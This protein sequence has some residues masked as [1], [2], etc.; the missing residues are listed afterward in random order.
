MNMGFADA[1]DGDRL[2][3]LVTKAGSAVKVMVAVGG[4]TFS[5][6]AT[7]DIFSTMIASPDNRTKF[8]A[9]AKS[10]ISAYGIAG[11]DI[12][13]EYPASVERGGPP[14]DTPNLTLFFQEF[15]AGLGSSALISLATPAGYWFL[16]GFE[17]DKISPELSFFNMMSY[18]YHGP[19]DTTVPGANSTAQPQSS[20][21]DM[22]D[23][24]KLYVKAGV[25][26]NKV[27]L[28]LAWYGRTFELEQSSCEGYNCDMKGGGTKGVCTGESGVLANFEINQVLI[29]ADVRPRLDTASQTNWFTHGSDL[30]TYDDD[31][32]LTAKTNFAKSACFGGTMIWS[33]DQNI[34]ADNADP[35]DGVAYPVVK[36][37]ETNPFGAL[38]EVEKA[39]TCK[40]YGTRIYTSRLWHIPSGQDWTEA[41]KGSPM[42]I[43]QV[44]YESPDVCD[45]LGVFGM[46]GTWYVSS[47]DS[48][49]LP[50]W[51]DKTEDECVDNSVRKWYARLW[52][53]SGD[54]D[55]M[56]MCTTT[57]ATVDGNHYD[58]PSQCDDKGILG[59]WGVWNVP[60][61]S[62]SGNWGS[63]KDNG[64]ADT[65]GKREWSSKLFDIV[66]GWEEACAARD[67]TVEDEYFSTPTKCEKHITGIWGVFETMDPTCGTPPC[68]SNKVW[69]FDANG[70][71]DCNGA[72]RLLPPRELSNFERAVEYNRST[73]AFS[74]NERQRR[75]YG[76]MT[77]APRHTLQKRAGD[78]LPFHLPRPA[79]DLMPNNLLAW[80]DD[81]GNGG[82]AAEGP[83]AAQIATR[84]EVLSAF[85]EAWTDSFP[86]RNTAQEI[87]HPTGRVHV[88][89]AQRSRSNTMN[90]T[91]PPAVAAGID[92]NN[93]ESNSGNPAPQGWVIVANFHTHPMGEA[94]GGNPATPSTADNTNAWGRGVPGIIVQYVVFPLSF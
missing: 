90:R 24:V 32:T 57:P 35:G 58:S 86:T 3:E 87:V 9:S 48:Y 53:I 62:C 51:G 88:R 77:S 22:Q 2:K 39:G 47:T 49:C 63:M 56:T 15:R 21:L 52:D 31:V 89:R 38:W 91:R 84:P 23:S 70:C 55:W 76:N 85:Q 60:D 10:F 78:C 61:K 11:I 1:T 13:F 43:N 14:S 18:D 67:N 4:W 82:G 54:V 40:S 12:D 64:C 28:G 16:K 29:D 73:S 71:M 8:I 50:H 72:G 83:T 80:L 81:N 79:P 19:W 30:I 65:R 59:A 27:N 46:Y 45:D 34:P 94:Y 92:L 93:P 37:L 36:G 26:M 44:R 42:I 20:L 6:G 17:L 68:P 33:I 41:C 74:K 25:D 66:G 7:K 75:S 5:Q 69:D